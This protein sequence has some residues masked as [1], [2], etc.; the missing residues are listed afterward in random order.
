[1]SDIFEDVVV[2]IDVVER[3]IDISNVARVVGTVMVI[4]LT[5]VALFV[6]VN[7]IRIA[8]YARRQEI[9]IMKLVGATDWFRARTV[10]H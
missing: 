6:I 5:G 7:T 8:V 1:M 10:R 3:L 2:P 4:A 9:E